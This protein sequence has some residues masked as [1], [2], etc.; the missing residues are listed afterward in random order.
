[1]RTKWYDVAKI[2]DSYH[3]VESHNL[4][5]IIQSHVEEKMSVGEKII[6]E[7]SEEIHRR[8]KVPEDQINALVVQTVE[9][10]LNARKPR[11]VVVKQKGKKEVK[12]DQ[13]HGSFD[14]LLQLVACRVPIFITGPAGSGKTKAVEQVALALQL[15]FSAISVG[16]QTTQAHLMGY[17]SATGSYVP[18]EFRKRFEHGGIFLIDEFDAGS[19]QVLTCLNSALSG[20]FCAFP[21]GMIKKHESFLCIATGNTYGNGANRIYVGRNQLDGATTDRFVFLE[22]DYCPKLERS[23]AYEFKDWYEHVLAVREKA[24]HLGMRVVISPR[25]TMYGAEL[26]R[27]GIPKK[28]VEKMVLYK[29]LTEVDCKRLI[30]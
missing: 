8:F 29:G 3:P 21:D 2:W 22:W 15:D 1:M 23:L 17:I 7:I 25:A 12:L 20:S 13:V 11:P 16:P 30:A 19:P 27:A 10:E 28:D 24:N 6:A 18:T 5:S 9:K 26:L 14:T 4:K